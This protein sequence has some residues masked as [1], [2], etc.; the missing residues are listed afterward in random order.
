MLPN[1]RLTLAR[2]G[3]LKRHNI[4]DEGLTVD[5]DTQDARDPSRVARSNV[6]ELGLDLRRIDSS[7]LLEKLA[8]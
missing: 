3:Y 2:A 4:Q 6:K 1:T 7:K 8:R 5:V